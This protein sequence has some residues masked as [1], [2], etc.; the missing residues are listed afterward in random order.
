MLD[1]F[2]KCVT[3]ACCEHVI[4]FVLEIIWRVRYEI[5]HLRTAEMKST[6][7]WSSLLWTQFIQLYS[8]CVQG[9]LKE[10]R[11]SMGFEPVTSQYWCDA[12]TNWAMKPLMLGTHKS[13]KTRFNLILFPL[14]TSTQVM[15]S[16]TWK[17]NITTLTNLEPFTVFQ[18]FKESKIS[19]QLQQCESWSWFLSSSYY[20]SSCRLSESI[21]LQSHQ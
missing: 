15:N 3:L 5:N 17:I 6:E 13:L 11:T 18:F 8:D 20:C 1:C 19:F 14:I 9:S 21:C 2:T 16:Q 7:E 4:V 12:L 10:F